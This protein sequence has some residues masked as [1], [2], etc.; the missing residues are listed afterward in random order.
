MKFYMVD[1]TFDNDDNPYGKFVFHMYTNM[2]GPHDVN[3]TE[4]GFNDIEVPIK[5]C[6]SKSYDW[7]VEEIRYYCTDFNDNHFLRG[8]F[9]GDKYSWMRLILHICD[10]STE[11]TAKRQEEKQLGLRQHA[12][13]ASRD[14]SIAYFEKTFI[15]LEAI[16]NEASVDQEFSKQLYD[17]KS[18]DEDYIKQE[19]LVVNSRKDIQYGI[20]TPGVIGYYNV[21]LAS[22]ELKYENSWKQ[23]FDS[24]WKTSQTFLKLTTID[25]G[26]MKAYNINGNTDAMN[27]NANNTKP[28]L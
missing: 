4:T 1:P 7:S 24:K 25:F 15:A 10:N 9:T 6:N 28:S 16:S 2:H 11:A 21:G 27:N 26:Q 17:K 18:E 8:G 20:K 12:E 22:S 14:E 5:T 19:D 13:C 3:G 23:Y